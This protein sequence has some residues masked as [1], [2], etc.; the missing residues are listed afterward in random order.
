MPIADERRR[1]FRLYERQNFYAGGTA[2]G[3]GF[4]VVANVLWEEE[5]RITPTVSLTAGSR[6]NVSANSLDII[7][8]QSVRMVTTAAAAGQFAASGELVE[9]SADL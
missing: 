2:S 1:A 8:A 9:G 7:S 5:K 3:A 4:V 6:V